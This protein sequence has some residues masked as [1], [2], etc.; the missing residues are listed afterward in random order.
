M[1]AFCG[2]LFCFLFVVFRILIGLVGLLRGLVTLMVMF[3]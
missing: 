3:A 2:C 1:G